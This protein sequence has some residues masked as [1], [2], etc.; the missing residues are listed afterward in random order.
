MGADPPPSA[1][2]RR[3][4]RASWPGAPWAPAHETAAGVLFGGSLD[5]RRLT[6]PPDQPERAEDGDL[7]HDQQE[8]DRQKTVHAVSL[9]LVLEPRGPGEQRLRVALLEPDR[10]LGRHQQR[11]A[12]AVARPLVAAVVEAV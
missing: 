8:E 9:A 4:V 1:S 10:R 6:R 3:V 11:G 7:E 5:L 12:R 2:A